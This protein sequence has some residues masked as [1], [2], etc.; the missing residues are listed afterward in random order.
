MIK[1]NQVYSNF[2]FRLDFH[3]KQINHISLVSSS[4]FII[5]N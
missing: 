3:R 2:P 5:E 4:R 1:N